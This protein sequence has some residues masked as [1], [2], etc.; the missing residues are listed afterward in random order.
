MTND[1]FSGFQL[2]DVYKTYTFDQ[3]KSAD[4]KESYLRAVDKLES[5]FTGECF[6]LEHFADYPCYVFRYGGAYVKTFGKGITKDQ[7]KASAVMEYAERISWMTYEPADVVLDSYNNLLASYD[8]SA[9]LPLVQS[10]DYFADIKQ[11]WIKSYNLTQNRE[12]LYPILWSRF[13]ERSNGLAAGNK[14][15]ET[16]LQ[17]I[18]EVIERHNISMA[19]ESPQKLKLIDKFSIEDELICNAIKQFKEEGIELLILDAAIDVNLNTIA[20]CGIDSNA[21]KYA[22][23]VGFGYGCHTNPK[24]AILRAITEY[25]QG[26]E[27]LIH[28]FKSTDIN[29]STKKMTQTVLRVDIDMLGKLPVVGVDTLKDISTNN[30]KTEIESVVNILK[31]NGYEVIIVDKTHSSLQIPVFRIFVPGLS[32]L[33]FKRKGAVDKIPYQIAKRISEG[34][35]RDSASFSE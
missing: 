21:D 18:C 6:K 28:N 33:V 22:L 1:N 26:R 16:I 27:K 11:Y 23:E 3:D 8:L 19:L 30:I 10:F 9:F 2:D 14:K 29:P 7:A 15:E 17:A 24:K 13:Y 25:Q 4:P 32:N 20:V 34:L 12:T 31:D 35:Y 5:A